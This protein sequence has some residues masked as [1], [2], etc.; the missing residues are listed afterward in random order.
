[1]VPEGNL[2]QMDKRMVSIAKQPTFAK[3][4][5]PN[6]ILSISYMQF[7]GISHTQRFTKLELQMVHQFTKAYLDP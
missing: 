3:L 1:M 4:R 2:S 6:V 7:F 5:H